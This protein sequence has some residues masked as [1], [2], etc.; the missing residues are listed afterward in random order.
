VRVARATVALFLAFD[1]M[2]ARLGSTRGEQGVLVAAVVLALILGT[3]RLLTGAP[4]GSMLRALGFG[5]PA[6]R[7]L[8]I[9]V[10]LSLLLLAF[11]PVF[12]AVTNTPLTVRSDW[13]VLG[14]GLLA[15]AGI[16]EET[17]FRGFLYR[18]FRAGRTFWRAAT[19]AAMPFVAAHLFL[20]LTLDFVVA[21]AAV[22]VSVSLTFPLARL[23]D[24]AGG[25]IWPGAIVHAVIQGA[26]KLVEP[27]SG[28][29]L[30]LSM[31]WMAAS[32]VVPWVV[33][34]VPTRSE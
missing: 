4:L 12:A 13:L 24:L 14:I 3:E 2:A 32:A 22:L 25:A 15:Q 17:L 10:G 7:A 8:A 6:P 34:A 31:A 11:F 1:G 27:A 21:L 9:A 16:A 26:I 20:F 33:F 5:R 19:L 30:P 18:H 28:D 23:F 29:A